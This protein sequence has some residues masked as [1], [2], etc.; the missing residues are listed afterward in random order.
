MIEQVKKAFR[1]PLD[2]I[3][4]GPQ[5][6]RLCARQLDLDKI[7]QLAASIQEIGLQHPITVRRISVHQE[8]TGAQ[9]DTYVLVAGLH[10]YKAVASLGH[11][12]IAV[13]EFDG[14]EIDARLWEISEN[15]HRA[16]LT[17][18]E[19]NEH[20]DEWRRLIQEKKAVQ[21]AP[22]GGEQP[23]DRA[24]RATAR[25]LGIEKTAVIRA[26]KIANIAP[27]AK[28][29]AREAGFDNNQKMLL[30]IAEAGED[31]EEQLARVHQLAGERDKRSAKRT[32]EE[33]ADVQRQAPNAR[34][35]SSSHETLMQAW[36]DAG[37]AER[38]QFLRDIRD[39]EEVVAIYGVD[40]TTPDF[41]RRDVVGAG[42]TGS[43]VANA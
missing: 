15:L 28:A 12:D 41:L 10:R 36:R 11:K 27:E 37:P 43:G 18:L 3:E 39:C 7:D 33:A 1:L 20:I 2:Q 17:K 6:G 26:T 24:I 31:V 14:D 13:V 9:T 8:E 22:P 42:P 40:L 29:A 21:L 16:E 4:V 38:K 25:E 23:T 34:S 35:S 32:A 19:R 30:Q 5:A